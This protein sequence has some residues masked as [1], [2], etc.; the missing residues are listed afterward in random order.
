MKRK[1]KGK[2]KQGG[3]NVKWWKNIWKEKKKGGKAT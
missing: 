3:G 1:G 2:G